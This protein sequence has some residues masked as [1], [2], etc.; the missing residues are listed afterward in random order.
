MPSEENASRHN[1]DVAYS[2]S[3]KKSVSGNIIN[4]K[5]LVNVFPNPANTKISVQ[6]LE[7]V[8][9][10][11]CKLINA[12]GQVVLKAN[13]KELDVKNISSGIYF[14]DVETEKFRVNKKII[15]RH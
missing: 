9:N 15:I 12:A 1:G 3:I 14:L 11:Q 7:A 5:E 4:N 8:T 10:Y 6:L 13:S 2:Y